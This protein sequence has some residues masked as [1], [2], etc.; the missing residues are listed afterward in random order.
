M[1]WSGHARNVLVSHNNWASVKT[2]SYANKQ[3]NDTSCSKIDVAKYKI[4]IFCT[5]T[6]SFL[7]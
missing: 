3:G 4:D 7:C 2:V 6:I 1:A 5:I